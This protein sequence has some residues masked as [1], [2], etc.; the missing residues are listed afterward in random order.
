M[1]LTVGSGKATAAALAGANLEDDGTG[2]LRIVAGPQL[3]TAL[4]IGASAGAHPLRIY[5]TPVGQEAANVAD[6]GV[7]FT[8]D[9]GGT[10]EL[11]YRDS[12]GTITQLTSA[13]VL[14]Q[15]AAQRARAYHWLKDTADA[16]AATVTQERGFARIAAPCTIQSVRYTNRVARAGTDVNNFNILVR[17]WRAGAVQGT[18]VSYTNDVASGGLATMTPKDMG[19]IVT[20]PAL[21]G[22][23]LAVS[24]NKNGTGQ[25]LDEGFLD[26]LVSETV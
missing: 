25:A 14:L 1:L 4:I 24:I 21:A 16:G 11:F 12:A 9:V 8:Q 15:S 6:S 20:A 7:I 26:V 2:K 13:G 5:E 23:W 18:V 10:T 17:L 22:D 3:T 19:G